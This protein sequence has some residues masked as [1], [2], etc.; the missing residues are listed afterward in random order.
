[1][2]FGFSGAAVEFAPAV[3]LLLLPIINSAF[4]VADLALGM[5]LYRR[6]ELRPLSYLF[7]T[8]MEQV[9]SLLQKREAFP[10]IGG[11]FC[12]QD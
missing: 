10:Q 5:F 12:F 1:M 11:R 2:H 6:I 7:R 8:R 9:N 4:F 3:R